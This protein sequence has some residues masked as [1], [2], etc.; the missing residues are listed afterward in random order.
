M[1]Y[2]LF[3][4]EDAKTKDDCKLEEALLAELVDIVQQRNQIVDTIDQDRIREEEE[5]KSIAEMMEQSGKS[6]L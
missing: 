2:V 5:D 4:I 3:L 6:L 1:F